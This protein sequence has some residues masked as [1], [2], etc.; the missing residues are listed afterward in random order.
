MVAVHARFHYYYLAAVAA[1]YKTPKQIRL[2][3][4]L[5]LKM[6]YQ[7]MNTFSCF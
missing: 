1:R 7:G 6:N 5:K 3:L 2:I 4:Y